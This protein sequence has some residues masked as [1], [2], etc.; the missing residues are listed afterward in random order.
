MLITFQIL[1]FLGCD[2]NGGPTAAGGEAAADHLLLERKVGEERKGEE[3]RKKGRRKGS[4]WFNTAHQ[5]H[6]IF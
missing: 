4:C 5:L 6:K 3:R 2:K 1:I